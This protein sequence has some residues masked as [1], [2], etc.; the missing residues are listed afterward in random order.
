ML[1]HQ[2]FEK[3]SST[4]TYFLGQV[5][6]G[7]VCLIDPVRECIDDYLALLAQYKVT[8]ACVF[9]TH[10]HADHITASGVLRQKTGCDIAMSEKTKAQGV[11]LFLSDTQ[12]ITIAGLTFKTLYTPGHTEDSCCFLL[13][14]RLFTG[15]TLLIN[16]SGRTDFQQGNAKLAYTM[17]Q[18]K[19]L[20]L[21]NEYLIYPGHDYSGRCVS[22]ILEQKQLNPRLQVNSANE[23][24]QL[25]AS[26]NLAYPKRI[27]EALPANLQCGL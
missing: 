19:L 1:F 24:A 16:G 7:S 23:Y 9:D 8:L 15:D 13:K 21:P 22:T 17:I 27:D 6:Q 14:D 3:K 4:Y 25:M 10:T 20:S 11:T 18:E 5:N 2:L 26:L 12:R